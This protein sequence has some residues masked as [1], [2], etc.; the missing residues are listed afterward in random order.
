MCLAK[1]LYMRLT[2]GISNSSVAFTI[3][4][5]KYS[6]A[7]V[8]NNLGGVLPLMLAS[9]HTGNGAASLPDDS[10]RASLCVGGSVLDTTQSQ[11][12]GIQS[13]P[14]AQSVTLNTPAY[15]FNP[16]Y[17]QQYLSKPIKEINY[18]DIYQYSI[19]NIA[20]NAQVN[21][22]ISNGVADMR[23]LILLPFF[24]KNDAGNHASFVEY[25]SPFST[26]GGGTTA[27]C[28]HVS[29]LNF[30]VSGM[31][32]FYN[33]QKYLYQSFLEQLYGLNAINGGQTDGLNSSLVSQLDFETS[34]A[35]YVANIER[36][37]PIERSVPKSLSVQFQN[38][39]ARMCDYIL[40]VEYG[41][42]LSIDIL[43]GSKVA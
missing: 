13:S 36:Q 17:E 5:D 28:A 40:F 41:Q 23:K 21:Q 24:S 14:L 4:S 3:A 30:V 29:N 38:M 27:L 39:S 9:T 22:L 32:V 8:T 19:Q 7:T 33:Q 10:Y 34:Y 11:I 31:N 42:S 1:G 16:I 37:L 2:A 43:T 25:N 6:A 12:G 20:A 18:T 26:A 35:Y 15:V